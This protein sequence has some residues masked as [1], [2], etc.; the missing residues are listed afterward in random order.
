MNTTTNPLPDSADMIPAEELR[1][2]KP[3]LYRIA[4]ELST[5]KEPDKALN[6]LMAL[7]GLAF[8]QVDA[9]RDLGNQDTREEAQS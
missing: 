1:E 8:E 2:K 5:F 6:V 4:C 9:I 3:R 7:A